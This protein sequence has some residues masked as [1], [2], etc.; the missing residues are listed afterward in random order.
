M[1]S[2]LGRAR[3][4]GSAKKGV[5]HWW[6]QRVTAAALVPLMLWLSIA[7]IGGVGSSYATVVAWL[8][9]PLTTSLDGAS[10]DCALLPHRAGI[11]G[12]HRGLRPLRS[13]KASCA[14]RGAPCV[15]CARS[16]GHCHG[17]AHCLHKLKNQEIEA[18]AERRDVLC[19]KLSLHEHR[20][21][22]PPAESRCELACDWRPD[23]L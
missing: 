9:A 14:G 21:V 2:P 1:R 8:R 23:R 4:L 22:M 16:Y 19:E 17:P 13:D 6:V 15:R 11:A 3:G 12:G 10:A 18:A 7:L 5:E 20:F